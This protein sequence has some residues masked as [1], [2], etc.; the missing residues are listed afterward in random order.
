[1]VSV[2]SAAKAVLADNTLPANRHNNTL[3]FIS[4]FHSL[5]S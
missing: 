2:Y 4:F 5:T 3:Y 1:M